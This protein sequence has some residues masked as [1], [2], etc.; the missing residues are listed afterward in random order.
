MYCKLF[1]LIKFA[2]M[3]LQLPFHFVE[4]RSTINELQL[5][6]EPNTTRSMKE[7]H[8]V[9]TDKMNE[10]GLALSQFSEEANKEIERLKHLCSTLSEK[11]GHLKSAH[12]SELAVY[13]EF[14]NWVE[15]D[16]FC[17]STRFREFRSEDID[18]LLKDQQQSIGSGGYGNVYK[19][20][21]GN[22]SVAVKILSSNGAQGSREFQTE[23]KKTNYSIIRNGFLF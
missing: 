23:V 11:N 14:R 3:L 15:S 10:N 12:E 16:N 2:F 6:S 5:P 21:L 13:E 1:E 18:Q 8:V 20:V 7:G 17:R 4:K 19:A 22:D 9:G